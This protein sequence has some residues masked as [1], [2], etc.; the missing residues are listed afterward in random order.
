MA[1]AFNLKCES[2]RSDHRTEREDDPCSHTPSSD[3]K[4]FAAPRGDPNAVY[5]ETDPKNLK[6]NIKNVGP[7]LEE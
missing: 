6:I 3:L 5:M 7:I 1:H 4:K 2:V